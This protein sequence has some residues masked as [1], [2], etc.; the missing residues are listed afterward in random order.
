MTQTDNDFTLLSGGVSQDEAGMILAPLGEGYT[1]ICKSYT[2]SKTA[3]ISE[4]SCI[5]KRT[6][7]ELKSGGHL[8]IKA[9]GEVIL[10]SS[11]GFI[12][13]LTELSSK[14]EPF[15]LTIGAQSYDRMLLKDFSAQ[16]DGY[17]RLAVCSVEF[18][19]TSGDEDE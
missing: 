4:L 17:G 12:E 5:S 19:Q 1:L 10:D 2:L 3:G 14:T 13:A 18:V 8:K 6:V 7:T 16:I 11:S 15:T 9:K